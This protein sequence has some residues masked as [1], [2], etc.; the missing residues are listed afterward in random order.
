MSQEP[1][2]K[3]IIITTKAELRDINEH[4]EDYVEDRNRK[5]SVILS[6]IGKTRDLGIEE[7][8]AFRY[9][10][11]DPDTSSMKGFLLFRFFADEN[12]TGQ[13]RN[14]LS[15]VQDQG[16]IDA[17]SDPTNYDPHADAQ[18]RFGLES[19][20][21]K[22]SVLFRNPDQNVAQFETILKTTVAKC[23]EKFLE[24]F[25]EPPQDIWLMSVFLH[26]FLNSLGYD[27]FKEGA[28]RGFPFM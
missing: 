6:L 27:S 22:M 2:W 21:R 11:P 18:A 12:T 26:L 10:A 23:V 16:R 24:D 3:Q 28:I 15:S 1:G 7:Y 8:H 17:F 9:V 19:T 4:P 20:Q 25:P 13:I 14:A 5:N